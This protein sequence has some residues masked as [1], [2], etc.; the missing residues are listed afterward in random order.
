M[1]Y[2]DHV[3]LSKSRRAAVR[4]VSA[5]GKDVYRWKE[6]EPYHISVGEKCVL[7]ID[8]HNAKR[9]DRDDEGFMG[10]VGIDVSTL[11]TGL[12]SEPITVPLRNSFAK[13]GMHP[14]SITMRVN[15]CP[16]G[17]CVRGQQSG[18]AG[19]W[20]RKDTGDGRFYFE[21]LRRDEGVSGS[22]TAVFERWGE[23]EAV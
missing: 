8:V 4:A 22:R 18:I 10:L 14:G 15:W 6:A 7:Y 3:R 11:P 17:R 9:R 5:A 12:D 13:A 21:D 16:L 1:V 19:T 2:I 23:G 20:A